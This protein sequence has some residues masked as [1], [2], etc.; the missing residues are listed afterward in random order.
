MAADKLLTGIGVIAVG[1]PGAPAST[2]PGGTLG[3]SSSGRTAAGGEGRTRFA[4]DLGL[5][6]MLP[7]GPLSKTFSGEMLSSRQPFSASPSDSSS[8][9][10][11][12]TAKIAMRRSGPITTPVSLTSRSGGSASSAEDGTSRRDCA[13]LSSGSA[14][15]P[16][17]GAAGS[18]FAGGERA[19]SEGLSLLRTCPQSNAGL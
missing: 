17:S 12:V 16:I 2:A 5:S 6:A 18:V 9:L 4:S 13:G 10:L 1:C 15:C 14:S 3:P 8:E 19:S 7:A 11:P